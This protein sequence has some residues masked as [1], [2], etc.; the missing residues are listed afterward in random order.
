[1]WYFDAKN[2]NQKATFSC[3][4][5]LLLKYIL[6]KMLLTSRFF[7]VEITRVVHMKGCLISNESQ[8]EF[9]WVPVVFFIGKG[10]PVIFS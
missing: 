2:N 5:A 1:M 4:K 3:L 7:W 9:I 6:M 10:V 8:V